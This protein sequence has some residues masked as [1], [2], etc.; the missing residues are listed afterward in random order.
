MP[1]PSQEPSVLTLISISVIVLALIWFIRVCVGT[2]MPFTDRA[3]RWRDY[4]LA[5]VMVVASIGVFAVFHQVDVRNYEQREEA[6]REWR[7]EQTEKGKR[8]QAEKDMEEL[9]REEEAWR[10]LI[11]PSPSSSPS[12]TS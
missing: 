3:P 9:M 2:N 12:A 6:W 5:A 11:S 7:D 1:V 4:G 8:E 10:D